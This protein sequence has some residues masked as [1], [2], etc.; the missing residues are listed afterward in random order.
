V[1]APAF[2]YA[3]TGGAGS[4]I[5]MGDFYTGSVWPGQYQ[6]A[7]FYSDIN[8]QIIR[9]LS[10][11]GA[12]NV[13]ADN[14]FADSARG[15]AQIRSGPDSNLYYVDVYAGE[16]RRI[17]YTAGG[18]APPTAEFDASPLSG[19]A[20]LTVDFD[21]SESF[22]PDV[23]PLT[24][25]WT[26]GD[27]NTGTGVEVSHTYVAGGDYTAVLRVSD[28]SGATNAD[29]KVISAGNAA[30]TATINSITN[31]GGGTNFVIGDTIIASGGGSDPEDGALPGTALQW[32][33]RLMHNDHFHLDYFNGEG[34]TVTMPFLDHE[35]NSRLEVCL[36]AVD[37][38][39]LSDT[40]CQII[41]PQTISLTINSSPGGLQIAYGTGFQTTPFTVN[42]PV[43]ATRTLGAALTQGANE[44]LSW[45]N[46]GDAAQDYLVPA[47]NTT[48]VATYTQSPGD[49]TLSVADA[50]VAENAGPGQFVVSLNRASAST[51]TVRAAAVRLSATPGQDHYGFFRI[52]EFAP[53]ETSKTINV[54]VIDDNT[55]EP[56][57]LV[58]VRLYRATNAVLGNTSA[59]TRAARVPCR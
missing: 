41:N 56:S 22:D 53:G 43:G 55:P 33:V 2:A 32:N 29:S 52:L 57:E 9:Y 25:N 51:V 8:R 59:T 28:T 16:I 38:G 10:F 42:A 18:N 48:L 1:T 3:H 50:S 5:Q 17:L 6:N 15:I 21:A 27:G 58:G 49:A 40:T 26:F 44:F 7:L 23:D 36:T 13:S 20:P 4:S 24:Y 35:D 34:S 19:G 31:S 46:G 30:P 14:A 39:E 11:D 45:S 37:S 54:T 47:N 12:G